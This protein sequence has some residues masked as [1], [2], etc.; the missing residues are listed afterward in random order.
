MPLRSRAPMA[1]GGDCASGGS[2]G[3]LLPALRSR[4]APRLR[5]PLPAQTMNIAG[6]VKDWMLVCVSYYGFHAPVTRLTLSGYI[7]CNAGV[8]L[9]QHQKLV[10]TRQR[11]V[12]DRSRRLVCVCDC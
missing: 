11:V 3:E 5:R 9:Y 10:Q 7:F 12:A 4:C 6:V 1:L 8:A 2:A